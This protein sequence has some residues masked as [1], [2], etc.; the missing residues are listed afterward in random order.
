MAE[1]DP[2]YE[3]YKAREYARWRY[4]PEQIKWLLIAEAPPMG[5]QSLLLF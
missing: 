1:A 3:A 2:K 5:S 4:K